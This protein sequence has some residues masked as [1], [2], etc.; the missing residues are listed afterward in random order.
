[1][2]LECKVVIL[3]GMWIW[4][5]CLA[6]VWTSPLWLWGLSA[7]A[8]PVAIH[9]WKRQHPRVERW[10]A[11]QFLQAALERTARRMRMELLAL[12]AVRCL[13]LA[14]CALALSGPVSTNE[15][16]SE[17]GPLA[18]HRILVIDG[19]ASMGARVGRERR[20]DLIR[21]RAREIVQSASP[22][23]SFNLC[24]IGNAKPT[25]IIRRPA[26]DTSDVLREID[27]LPLLDDAGDLTF[28]L[29]QVRDLIDQLP[30]QSAIEV[31][32]LSDQQASNWS[33]EVPSEEVELRQ[34]L[35]DL[36]E[37]GRLVFN[38]VGLTSTDDNLSI[39]NLVTPDRVAVAERPLRVSAELMNHTEAE[40][41]VSV[42]FLADGIVRNVV[43][44]VIPAQS[45]QSV[46]TFLEIPD[47]D[48]A[49]ALEARLR[50]DS[51]P[52]DNVTRRVVPHRRTLRLL[53]V[54][55]SPGGRLAESASGFV[56]LALAPRSSGVMPLDS[57]TAGPAGL[58][59]VTVVR[60]AQ[61]RDVEMSQTECVILC[62]SLGLGEAETAWLRRY[63]ENGG[64]LVIG[65]GPGTDPEEFARTLGDPV[66]GLIPVELLEVAEPADGPVFFDT[67]ELNHPVLELFRG[68]IEAGL[69]TA[70]VA[71][72]YRTR[73]SPMASVRVVIPWTTGDA[74][75]LESPLGQGR[76]Q[77]VTTSLDDHWGAWVL[78]P[79]FVPLM[80]RMVL[81][82]ME[83]RLR[84]EPV[85]VGTPWRVVLPGVISRARIT[86]PTG[87]I[88]ELSM[89]PQTDPL[90]YA[91]ST[92]TW[93][94][95]ATAGVYRVETTP[96]SGGPL[97]QAVVVDRR[98][99]D[100]QVLTMDQLQRG[101][102]AG[103]PFEI[104]SGTDFAKV[105]ADRARESTFHRWPL[106]LLWL[107]LGLLVVESLLAGN[108]RWG[109]SAAIVVVGLFVWKI[110]A[111]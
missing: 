88:R 16:N 26:F 14:L 69:A 6:I 45:Q 58:F 109:L 73:I 30:P 90:G 5:P 68:R 95:T 29:R 50:S 55:S 19:S 59:E 93:P 105:D 67:R 100:P 76:V 22:G 77:L 10:A 97:W 107:V 52:F 3:G 75:L 13:L 65:L 43:P 99:S 41:R 18:I 54:D 110:G 103:V 101:A 34:L 79:S 31:H 12:L 33:S 28:A 40:S 72:Y 82:A 49:I 89:E 21:K 108:W 2:P 80:N 106:Q 84:S 32:L 111:M 98:E 71:R 20:F 78:W 27:R 87:S 94:E 48:G 57:Q 96:V 44:V 35:H 8:V 91:T 83:G 51:M 66:K 7:L 85:T 61:L 60:P 42:E 47:A 25:V 4:R 86:P 62:D 63:V 104:A 70:P 24:R 56:R 11:M 1:M 36:D 53:L 81:H 39:A 92:F 46:S 38:D 37:R 74:A 64:G 17:S 23:D 9:L 102:L 15:S